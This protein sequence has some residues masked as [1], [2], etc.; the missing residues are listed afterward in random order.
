MAERVTVLSAGAKA[1]QVVVI[2]NKERIIF[3]IVLNNGVLNKII[4]GAIIFTIKIRTHDEA[5]CL[6]G[7]KV[8]G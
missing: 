5:G 3:F 2:I 4:C 7:C 8:F 1:A 6:R